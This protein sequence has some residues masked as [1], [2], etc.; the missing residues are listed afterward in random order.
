MYKNNKTSVV[1]SVYN[2]KMLIKFT[3]KSI[4]DYIDKIYTELDGFP[5]K[6][7]ESIDE[8]AEKYRKIIPIKQEFNSG[9]DAEIVTGYK[10]SLEDGIDIASSYG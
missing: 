8:M 9:T 2:E 3:L 4:P 7:F 5:D 10:R 6:T 1:V